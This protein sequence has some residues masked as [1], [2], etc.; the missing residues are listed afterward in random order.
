MATKMKNG[1]RRLQFYLNEDAYQQFKAEFEKFNQNREEKGE[2]KLSES[3]FCQKKLTGA[4]PRF[5]GAPKGNKNALDRRSTSLPVCAGNEFSEAVKDACSLQKN[6]QSIVDDFEPNASSEN[7]SRLLAAW[8]VPDN[9][10]TL[11]KDES[12]GNA[13]S[14]EM[15][16]NSIAISEKNSTEILPDKTTDLSERESHSAKIILTSKIAETGTEDIQPSEEEIDELLENLGS[17]N[18]TNGNRIISDKN[19][20]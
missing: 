18:L 5:R 20:R 13:S 12:D 14:E 1:L 11:L 17:R 2:S 10:N 3:G 19:N 6:Q 16:V 15:S 4:L 7:S 9:D 8:S